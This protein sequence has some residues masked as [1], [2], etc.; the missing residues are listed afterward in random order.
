MLEAVISHQRALLVYGFRAGH[1]KCKDNV[2]LL[3][4]EEL[5]GRD[6]EILDPRH[7]IADDREAGSL[8]LQLADGGAAHIVSGECCVS[9]P[10]FLHAS[11]PPSPFAQSGHICISSL[12]TRHSSQTLPSH[13]SHL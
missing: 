13:F 1:A 11:S 8:L 2:A 7:R 10:D 4:N 12:T 9:N 6:G 3:L 5:L